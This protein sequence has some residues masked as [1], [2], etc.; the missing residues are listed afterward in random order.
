MARQF[1]LKTFLDFATVPELNPPARQLAGAVLTANAKAVQDPKRLAEL[2]QKLRD[3]SADA[4]AEAIAGLQGRGV[5]GIEALVA[6]L[7]DPKRQAE[8]D[9]AES[10]LVQ[11]GSDAAGPMLGNPCRRRGLDD[12]GDKVA[13]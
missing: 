13:P 10:A 9:A 12:G 6:V 5:A 3:P 11:M 4:R 2:I 7:A 8:H 1:S